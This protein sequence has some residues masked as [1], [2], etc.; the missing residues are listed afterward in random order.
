M[1]REVSRKL[2]SFQAPFLVMHGGK[3]LVMRPAGSQRLYNQAAA[4][5]KTL[6]WFP[7][8]WH[9]LLVEPEHPEVMRTATNWILA[10][11]PGSPDPTPD[12]LRNL[13]TIKEN[14]GT[15]GSNISTIKE[16]LGSNLDSLRSN[17]GSNL[18]TIKE[19][20]GSNLDNLRSNLGSN[21]GTIKENLGSFLQQ[22][23]PSNPKLG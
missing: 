22:R 3:D 6:R 17:L 10:H 23:R 7:E 13:G 12:W 2:D 14:L 19:N 21:L 16:N 1:L 5:D 8:A 20:L 11:L 4:K 18:G 9:E 15:L